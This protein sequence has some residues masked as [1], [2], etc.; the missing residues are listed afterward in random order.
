MRRDICDELLVPKLVFDGDHA[1]MPLLILA[2]SRVSAIGMCPVS[3]SSLQG[4]S[5]FSFLDSSL[6]RV[7]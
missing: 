4:G 7:S 3:V 2:R 5:S 6:E 1:S